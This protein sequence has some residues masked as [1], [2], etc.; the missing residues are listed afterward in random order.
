MKAHQNWKEL[1]NSRRRWIGC[2]NECIDVAVKEHV[3][4]KYESQLALSTQILQERKAN[5]EVLH[6]CHMYIA[7]A[8]NRVFKKK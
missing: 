8:A 5:A 2:A 7:E 3:K 1:E 4:H 6:D